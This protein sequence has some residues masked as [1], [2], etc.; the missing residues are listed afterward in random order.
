MQRKRYSQKNKLNH[1]LITIHWFSISLRMAPKVF[2]S[3]TRAKSSPQ[4]HHANSLISS[5]IIFLLILI[6]QYQTAGYASDIP[7]TFLPHCNCI[8]L[9]LEKVPL[10]CLH[11]LLYH[12]FKFYAQLWNS[13]KALLEIQYKIIS[14]FHHPISLYSS[15]KTSITNK[16]ILFIQSISSKKAKTLSVFCIAISQSW[17]S[18]QYTVDSKY[19]LNQLNYVIF[20]NYL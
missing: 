20:M 12:F 15:F 1:V 7:S 16:C 6:Q 17:D 11:G 18:S 4:T 8:F 14:Y 2:P 10:K 19:L 5:P 9:C 3:Q 13:E